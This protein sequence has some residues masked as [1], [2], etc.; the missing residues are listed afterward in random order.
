MNFI[1]MDTS[2]HKMRI[3]GCSC[4]REAENVAEEQIGEDLVSV[5]PEGWDE[6]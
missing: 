6:V 1:A 3:F 4:L 2:G 5:V